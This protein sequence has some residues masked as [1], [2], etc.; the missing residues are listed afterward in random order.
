VLAA[1]AILYFFRSWSTLKNW[2]GAGA[3]I[4]ERFVQSRHFCRQREGSSDA[5]IRTLWCKKS[6]FFKIY[7][8]SVRTSG[9]IWHMALSVL[10]ISNVKCYVALQSIEKLYIRNTST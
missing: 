2:N 4:K 6:R 7:G 10:N 3:G 1:E 9:P 5:D 8:A